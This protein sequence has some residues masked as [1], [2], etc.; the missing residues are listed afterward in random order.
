MTASEEIQQRIERLPESLQEKVLNFIESL[1]DEKEN[2]DWQHV[3]LASAVR[4]M[5]DEVTG[6]GVQELR[7]EDHHG[8][9]LVLVGM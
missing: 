3:S 4:G 9:K 6:V 2:A 5:E 7:W 8:A 1:A